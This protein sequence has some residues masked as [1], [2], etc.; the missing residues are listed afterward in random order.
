MFD[1]TQK[2]KTEFFHRC[3][4]AVDGLW[5]MKVEEAYGFD[6]ALDIDDAVWRIM[7]KIQARMF[8]DF[9]KQGTGIKALYECFTTKHQLEGFVFDADMYADGSGF[10]MTVRQCPWHDIMIKSGREHLSGAVGN[11]ICNTENSVWA[12]EF[13]DNIEGAL[14][15]QICSGSDVCRFRFW[16]NSD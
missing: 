4:T 3:F 14:E 9:F 11:R 5:F 7:P 8:K 12:M 16:R 10:T 1:L 13:G 6:T 15:E 2:Q